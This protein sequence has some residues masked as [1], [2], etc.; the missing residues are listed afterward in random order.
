M[1]AGKYVIHTPGTV[2]SG[3]KRNEEVLAAESEK[4]RGTGTYTQEELSERLTKRYEGS[5]KRND[6]SA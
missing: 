5:E 1:R 2:W 4:I 6:T 3:G